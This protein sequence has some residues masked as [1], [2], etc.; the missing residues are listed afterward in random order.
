MFEIESV[1]RLKAQYIQI[2]LDSKLVTGQLMGAFEVKDSQMKSCLDIA[3]S[4]LTEFEF[5]KI[6][7]IK[8]KIEFSR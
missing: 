7:A 1:L 3:K 5:A 2:N 4:I 6:K 8:K